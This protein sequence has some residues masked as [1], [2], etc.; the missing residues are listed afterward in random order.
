MHPFLGSWWE[1]TSAGARKADNFDF[2]VNASTTLQIYNRTSS[3][4]AQRAQ[5]ASSH[6]KFQ[7]TYQ[8]S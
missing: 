3:R 8:V 1:N 4:V 7:A 2:Q 6:M 5:V